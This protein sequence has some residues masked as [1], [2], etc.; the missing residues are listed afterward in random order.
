[1]YDTRPGTEYVESLS[2]TTILLPDRQLLGFSVYE[3]E[4]AG[5][6]GKA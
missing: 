1:M 5:G 6:H 2:R 3:E 4:K